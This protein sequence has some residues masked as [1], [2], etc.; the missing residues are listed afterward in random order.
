MCCGGIT[1]DILVIKH[2]RLIGMGIEQR[3]NAGL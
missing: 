2:V 1:R 3:K